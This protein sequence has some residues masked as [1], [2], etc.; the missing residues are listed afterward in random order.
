MGEDMPPNPWL[1]IDAATPPALRALELRRKWE[2]FLSGGSVGGVRAPVAE[3]W[4]RS[5]AAGVDPSGSR[6]GSRRRRS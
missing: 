4:Q 2:E 1:A 6:V 3:S 5:L